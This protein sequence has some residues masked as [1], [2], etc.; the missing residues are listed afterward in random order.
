MA[1][2]IKSKNKFEMVAR[3]ANQLPDYSHNRI[4]S[5]VSEI[6]GHVMKHKENPVVGLEAAG[7]V[8]HLPV[9]KVLRSYADKIGMQDG[10]TVTIIDKK[11][12]YQVFL[13]DSF[14]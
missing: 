6:T 14:D 3:A 8:K 1:G 2:K 12:P 11:R 10:D 9:A 13:V 4:K 5:T 7:I